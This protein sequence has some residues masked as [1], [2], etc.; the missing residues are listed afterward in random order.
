MSGYDIVAALDAIDPASLDYS[1]WL[2]VGQALHYEGYDSST[3]RDWS[4]RDSK[5]FNPRDFESKWRGFG[6]NIGDPV[7]GGTIVKMAT[8]RGWRPVWK[9]GDGKAHRALGWDSVIG[10]GK[11]KAI[12][13]SDDEPAIVDAASVGDF[14]EEVRPMFEAGHEAEELGSYLSA[15]FDRSEYVGYVC[16]YE[17]KE[18]DGHTK[19]VPGS[20][21]VYSRTMGDIYDAVCKSG[22]ENGLSCT[23]HEESGAWIRFNPLDGQGVGNANVTAYRY[24]L[25]ESDDMPQGKFAAIVKQ[26][27]LPVAA[28]VDSGNKSLH[29]I[30]RIDAADVKQFRERVETLYSRCEKN[31]IKVDKANKNPSRLSR[32]PGVTRNGKRQFLAGLSQ[33]AADWDEWDEWYAAETDEL[34]DAFPLDSMLGDNLPPLKPALIDG[35]LRVGHKMLVSGPSKAGKSFALIAL[36]IAFAE[37][38]TWFGFRCR[39]SRVMYVNLELDGD[40]CINRFADMYAALGMKPEHA[41]EIDVWNLRGKSE[42]MSRLLPKM[43]RRARKRGV[44]VVVIDPIYKV[45]AGDENSAGDMAAFANLFDA[46][47]DQAGVSAIYCH[48]HSKGSQADKRSIDRASGSGVFGRD[49]DAIVDMI[50]LDVEEGLRWQRVN[51]RICEA[52]ED[53]V[54]DAGGESVWLN[55]PEV[56]RKI[57]ANAVPNACDLLDDED[58]DALR[59]RCD[60]IRASKDALTAWKIE[61]TLREFPRFSP[62]YAWFDWPLHVLDP[63]LSECSE[64]GSE[65]SRGSG[66]KKQKKGMHGN[67]PVEDST[68]VYAEI[69]AAIAKAVEVCKE[70]G[71]DPTRTN[72][73]KRIQEVQGKNPTYKQICHWTDESKPWCEWV[74]GGYI[75]GAHRGQKA[76]VRRPSHGKLQNG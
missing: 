41:S 44:E 35:L 12:A 25:L 1:E 68:K 39:K 16:D 58:A 5:R 31:G 20:R 21:G 13:D 33:G 53:A 7:T 47:C 62:V 9:D 52:C 34:P 8:D 15:L 64:V 61:G 28:L 36:C 74:P 59:A 27:N 46:L 65:Q 72:I 30:V 55:L 24:A 60:A 43:V 42:P 14:D 37:G 66:K 26:L 38:L 76:I 6:E 48:H 54:T 10:G 45:M 40:S 4:A 2:A 51:R 23:L 32:M 69:N 17:E 3:W 11:D 75:E 71:V 49:P 22:V 63:A 73:Q 50:E 18:A 67:E 56:A 70:D 29:A 57:E 19:L